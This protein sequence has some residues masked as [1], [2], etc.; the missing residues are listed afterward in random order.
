[1]VA[2]QRKG[3]PRT[4]LLF[5]DQRD[6]RLEGA[7]HIGWISEF[8]DL[9]NQKR[10][11]FTKKTGTIPWLHGVK[12]GLD[13]PQVENAHVGQ[14]SLLNPYEMVSQMIFW[15]QRICLGICSTFSVLGIIV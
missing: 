9:G 5:W 15:R 6:E 14:I 4:R 8:E 13:K 1:M 3:R 11:V 10:D 12:Q 7:G 2:N